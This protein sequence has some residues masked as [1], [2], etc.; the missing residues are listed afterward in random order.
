MDHGLQ[1][2]T[3]PTPAVLLPRDAPN[4][5]ARLRMKCAVA[6]LE[7]S[8]PELWQ[9]NPGNRRFEEVRF[10]MATKTR[11][12]IRGQGGH[13]E[14]R[15]HDPIGEPFVQQ[16]VEQGCLAAGV[17][18]VPGGLVVVEALKQGSGCEGSGLRRVQHPKTPLRVLQAGHF[19]SKYDAS[20]VAEAASH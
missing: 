4:A 7:A 11:K 14:Q 13:S 20:L 5:L 8:A 1:R 17:E 12:H 3:T 6:T 2:A 15:R 19:S 18:R 16:A 9:R 10:P